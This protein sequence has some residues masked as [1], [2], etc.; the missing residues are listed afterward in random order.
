MSPCVHTPGDAS[1]TDTDRAWVAAHH[2]G[3]AL[4]HRV[5]ARLGLTD[6][7]YAALDLWLRQLPGAEEVGQQRMVPAG[8]RDAM[9]CG[10]HEREQV[11]IRQ[12]QCERTP[13]SDPPSRKGVT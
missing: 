1:V 13:G 9:R 7:D 3:H 12:L 10:Q 2:P 8:A 11:R 5:D 6:G 4:L